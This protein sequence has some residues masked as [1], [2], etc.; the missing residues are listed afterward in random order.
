[1]FRKIRKHYPEALRRAAAILSMEFGSSSVSAILGL[2]R[3]TIYRWTQSARANSKSFRREDAHQELRRLCAQLG[4]GWR[5]I[6][7]EI[8]CLLDQSA[9][10]NSPGRHSIRKIK[11]AVPR[12][13]P[14]AGRSQPAFRPPYQQIKEYIETHYQTAVSTSTLAL[15]F[16]LNEF[17]MIRAFRKIFGMPPH[18]YLLKIRVDHAA[19]ALSK[20]SDD[21]T[22]IA[23][24][25]GFGSTA[26]M[27]RAF[28]KFYGATPGTV[29]I[30]RPSI[31]PRM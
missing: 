29:P 20:T 27:T 8:E 31:L 28:K 2:P 30:S 26:S 5:S 23:K 25:V 17:S 22:A 12:I 14:E 11:S 10:L 18:Q 21:I 6:T 3:A 9:V 24:A 15:I 1:M 7:R 19:K 13:V 4:E 16:G